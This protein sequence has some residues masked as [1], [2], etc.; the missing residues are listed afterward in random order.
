MTYA[1]SD[2]EV[3]V[4]APDGPTFARS[5]PGNFSHKTGPWV[6]DGTKFYLQN[7]SR[8]LALTAENTIDVVTL[9]QQK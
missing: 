8:A 7:V 6:R 9:K 4:D 1:T 3:H 5:G 2:V